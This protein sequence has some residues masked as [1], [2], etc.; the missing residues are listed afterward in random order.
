MTNTL[1]FAF[2][3]LASVAIA[4][5]PVGVSNPLYD[6]DY[7]TNGQVYLDVWMM[8]DLSVGCGLANLEK[9]TMNVNDFKE[10][11]FTILGGSKIA[12]NGFYTLYLAAVEDR[13][14]GMS[15]IVT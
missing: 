4:E 11:P 7:Y 15:P 12:E 14:E 13:L 1:S 10:E 6:C 9:H 8:S 5:L 3:L 2:A